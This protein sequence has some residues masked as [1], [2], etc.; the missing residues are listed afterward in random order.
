M[1][2]R[3]H[4][5][6]L[7]IVDNISEHRSYEPCNKA[8][9]EPQLRSDSTR[10]DNSRKNT[11]RDAQESGEVL[12]SLEGSNDRFPWRFETDND[13]SSYTITVREQNIPDGVVFPAGGKIYLVWEGTEV[14]WVWSGGFVSA[15]PPKALWVLKTVRGCKVRGYEGVISRGISFPVGVGSCCA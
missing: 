11:F 6:R 15:I 10:L 5:L 8:L 1:P 13:G 7:H 14:K 3:H 4:D 12:L 2:L 9:R